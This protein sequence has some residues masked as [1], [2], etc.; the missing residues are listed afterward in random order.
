MDFRISRHFSSPRHPDRYFRGAGISRRIAD[1]YP[2]VLDEPRGD[3]ALIEKAITSL[4]A[5]IT[6]PISRFYGQV[7]GFVSN[8]QLPRVYPV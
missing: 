5:A 1:R 7:T 2:K 3:N 4:L 6:C 8:G